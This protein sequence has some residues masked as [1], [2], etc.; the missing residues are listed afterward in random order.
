MGR[1]WLK[2]GVFYRQSIGGFPGINGLK[3]AYKLSE[4][5]FKI[6]MLIDP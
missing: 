1:K 6:T 4:D 3:V 5:F 2:P